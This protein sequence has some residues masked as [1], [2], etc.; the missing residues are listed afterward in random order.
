M[1]VARSLTRR[2]TGEDPYLGEDFERLAA[3][4]SSVVTTVDGVPLAVREVGPN[5]APLT[6]VFAHGFCL[7]MGAFHFQ[8]IRLA[9]QWGSQVRMVFYDQRGHGQSGAAPPNT[10]TVEQLGRDLEAVVAVMVPRGP[11]VLVGH[12]MGGMTVLSHARQFPHRYPKQIV[13]AAL[14]SSAAEGVTRSPLGEILRNPALEAV[15]FLARYTPGAVHHTRGAARSVIGPIL[16]AASYGDEAVSPSVVE[17]SERMMHGTSITTLVEFLHALEVHDEGAA[18]PVLA[19][20]PTLIACGDRD[21]LTPMEYS[22]AM[23]AQLPRSELVIVGGAG[24][25]VQL[26][27]PVVIDDAL[28][29]LVER[30]TPSK[31]VT[32]TRRVRNRVRF[33]G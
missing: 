17:F 16:R 13:G 26:E 23:A 33:R 27:E 6:V 1:S 4:R 14:I 12:S 28:V 31:L 20:V 15:R 3:D 7:R 8:R 21:L 10:Y 5:D 32:L 2:S 22:K 29:R 19:K 25:L 24:H 18:L 9:E 30:A 11:A